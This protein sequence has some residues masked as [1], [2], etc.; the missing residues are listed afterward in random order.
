MV[1]MVCGQGNGNL[2]AHLITDQRSM[3]L[4]LE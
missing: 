4:I 2:D 1:R 3:D